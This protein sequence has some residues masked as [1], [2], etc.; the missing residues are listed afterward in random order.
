[1]EIEVLTVEEKL[2]DRFHEIVISPRCP[3]NPNFPGSGK[4]AL[5]SSVPPHFSQ[6][7]LKG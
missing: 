5:N 6:L 4:F 7:L 3:E 1:M 2:F